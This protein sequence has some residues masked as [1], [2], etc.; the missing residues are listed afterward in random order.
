MGGGEPP[1]LGQRHGLVQFPG[2]GSPAATGGELLL[3]LS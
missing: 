2:E 1:E 3:K